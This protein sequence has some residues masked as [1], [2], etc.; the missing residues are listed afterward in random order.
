MQLKREVTTTPGAA[1]MRGTH[2]L[3]FVTYREWVS[4]GKNWVLWGR[5]SCA[6]GNRP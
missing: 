4:L 2:D 6:I 3:Y 5:Q 1:Q